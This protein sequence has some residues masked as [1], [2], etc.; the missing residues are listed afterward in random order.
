M[1]GMRSLITTPWTST[2]APTVQWEVC[3][4]VN[5]HITFVVIIINLLL[6]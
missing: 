1:L 4:I 6:L 3:F 5:V 2:Q